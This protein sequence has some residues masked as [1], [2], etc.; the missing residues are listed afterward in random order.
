MDERRRRN[1][2]LKLHN[3]ALAASTDPEWSVK[4]RHEFRRLA[5]SLRRILQQ[6]WP[7]RRHQRARRKFQPPTRRSAPRPRART[8]APQRAAAAAGGRA[9]SPDPEPA[10]QPLLRLIVRH[11]DASD[12][13]WVASDFAENWM[14]WGSRA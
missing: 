12:V 1:R 11:A 2:I 9:P 14:C 4:E 7:D 8:T 3:Q 6:E 10:G 13:V 5:G